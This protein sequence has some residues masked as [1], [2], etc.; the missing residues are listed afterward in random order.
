MLKRIFSIILVI[1]WLFVIYSFSD[2]VGVTS[3]IQTRTL[4]E[5]IVSKVSKF[6]QGVGVLK[7]ELPK[8]EIKTI[9]KNY[10]PIFRKFCHFFV[11][12]MLGIFSYLS[13]LFLFNKGIWF[14]SIC[15]ICFSSTYSIF[16]ELHQSF[17]PGRYGVYTDC[18]IDTSGAILACILISLL[19]NYRMKK[20]Q[21]AT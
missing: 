1:L 16:D 6:L 19:L 15:T 7:G 3:G 10:H 11:Y 9:V 17:V 14:C 18:L 21:K 4:F 20:R 13:I 2:T 12:F 5:K 8:S